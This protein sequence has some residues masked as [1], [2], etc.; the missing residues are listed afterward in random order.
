MTRGQETSKRMQ[1]I[2]VDVSKLPFADGGPPENRDT[3]VVATKV[4]M[5]MYVCLCV[6]IHVCMHVHAS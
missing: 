6:C 1:C 5:C 2:G 3:V 4:C